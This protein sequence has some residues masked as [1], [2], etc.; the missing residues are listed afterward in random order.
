MF[1][2]Y[3]A[4]SIHKDPLRDN[5]ILRAIEISDKIDAS[6]NRLKIADKKTELNAWANDMDRFLD[7]FG[8]RLE[9][10]DEDS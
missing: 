10:E 3:S 4:A 5:P 1:A 6:E 7:N 9:K 2:D 8:S